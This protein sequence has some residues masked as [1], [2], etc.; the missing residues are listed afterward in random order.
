[1]ISTRIVESSSKKRK[2]GRPWKNENV[3]FGNNELV[4]REQIER[5]TILCDDVKGQNKKERGDGDGEQ[6]WS[7]GGFQDG[8]GEQ[9]GVLKAV[10]SQITRRGF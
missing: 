6:E 10:L 1:M 2:R 9:D 7:G 8:G 4:E 5:I 3:N